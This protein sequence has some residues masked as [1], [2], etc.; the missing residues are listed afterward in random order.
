MSD[1][2]RWVYFEGEPKRAPERVDI[3]VEGFY[4]GG[5]RCL[6]SIPMGEIFQIYARKQLREVRMGAA[7]LPEYCD[8]PDN[9]WV[10]F[11]TDIA[12]R[13]NP[14]SLPGK[15]GIIYEGK[16]M[17]LSELTPGYTFLVLIDGA[18]H[19]GNVVNAPLVKR[20]F[21]VTVEGRGMDLKKIQESLFD[22]LDILGIVSGVNLEPVETPPPVGVKD[23]MAIYDIERWVWFDEV[24]GQPKLGPVRANLFKEGIYRGE[25]VSLKEIPL[26]EKFLVH[27]EGKWVHVQLGEAPTS[28]VELR[29]LV[30]GKQLDMVQLCCRVMD[31]L[32]SDGTD[33]EV[34]VVHPKEEPVP[35]PTSPDRILLKRVETQGTREPWYVLPTEQVD[36][37]GK[38]VPVSTVK[39]GQVFWA[40]L[41]D[42]SGYIRAEIVV[43]EPEKA[44][45]A[46]ASPLIYPKTGPNVAFLQFSVEMH[47]KDLDEALIQDILEDRLNTLPSALGVTSPSVWT[48]RRRFD[49]FEGL[50]EEQMRESI[51]D[52]LTRTEGHRVLDDADHPLTMARYTMTQWLKDPDS[53]GVSGFAYAFAILTRIQ[54]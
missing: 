1:R 53:V 32:D 48:E 2:D 23:A 49:S 11:E 38:I 29:V 27:F 50:S 36:L 21:T 5:W 45:P 28:V 8:G 18:L 13:P 46:E 14:L 22:S 33:V 41:R 51:R 42:I 44:V 24:A 54:W 25:R 40:Y 34:S 35:V 10:L 19:R 43:P 31:A 12:G 52:L 9:F 3:S 7:P 20:T 6:D 37:D 16:R 47:G 15:A 30:Q 39:P 17:P 26:T 4:R